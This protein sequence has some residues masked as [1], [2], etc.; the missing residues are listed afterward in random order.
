MKNIN[1]MQPP[2]GVP[3]RSSLYRV[4]RQLAPTGLSRLIVL[5]LLLLVLVYATCTQYI[6][7]DQ[8]AVKQVDVPVPLITGSAGIHTNIFQT[9]IQWRMPGCEKFLIF[10]KSVRT[11]TLHSQ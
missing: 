8:F 1:P 9:G 3:D 11:I 4:L 6:E 10:P 5:L 7:P 2:G